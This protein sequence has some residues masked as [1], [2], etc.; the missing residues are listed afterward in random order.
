[1]DLSNQL[2]VNLMQKNST[3]ALQQIEEDIEDLKAFK[4]HFIDD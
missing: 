4:E 1:M 3:S 2:I